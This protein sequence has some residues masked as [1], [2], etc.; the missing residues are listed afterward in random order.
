MRYLAQK[1]NK[2]PFKNYVTMLRGKGGGCPANADTNVKRGSHKRKSIHA[3]VIFE[4]PI[5]LK[6]EKR[7]S[8]ATNFT[9][10]D[11]TSTITNKS[12]SKIQVQ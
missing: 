11:N 9:I 6:L 10:S 12:I 2:K 1:G 8:A 7:H 4:W 5:S 3:D